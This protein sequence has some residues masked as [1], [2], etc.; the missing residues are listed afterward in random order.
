LLI[1]DARAVLP[2]LCKSETPL[3]GRLRTLLTRVHKNTVIVAL[4]NK[5]ACIARAVLRG[6]ETF[7]RSATALV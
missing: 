4:A 1:H 6:E 7:N 3:G 5:L 2:T